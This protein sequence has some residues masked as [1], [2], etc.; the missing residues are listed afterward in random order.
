MEQCCFPGLKFQF[1]FDLNKLGAHGFV[2]RRLAVSR[3]KSHV[4]ILAP[5]TLQL[6]TCATRIFLSTYLDFGPHTSFIVR[7]TSTRLFITG[8]WE[9]RVL[10]SVVSITLI[11]NLPSM[12]VDKFSVLCIQSYVTKRV[13]IASARVQGITFCQTDESTDQFECVGSRDDTA[14]PKQVCEDCCFES[15]IDLTL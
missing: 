3:G 12:C 11:C 2:Y 13:S 15:N 14:P 7:S 9:S 5:T 10:I 8:F 6:S 1:V 4:E